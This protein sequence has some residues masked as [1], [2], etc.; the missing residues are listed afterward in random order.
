MNKH[1]NKYAWITEQGFLQKVNKRG[2]E[3]ARKFKQI[4]LQQ[5]TVHG[6]NYAYQVGKFILK[7]VNVCCIEYACRMK[8]VTLQ[9]V[10]VHE[11]LW[12]IKGEE[13]LEKSDRVLSLEVKHV[14]DVIIT[15][16]ANRNIADCTVRVQVD[17]TK[18]T[19][20]FKRE[21]KDNNNIVTNKVRPGMISIPLKII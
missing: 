12:K 13:E 6:N 9:Q 3:Y 17:T 10:I 5:V 1:C 8:Q 21:L 15:D 20:D 19:N 4:T 7:Q 11:R 18:V 2:N 16:C 14:G